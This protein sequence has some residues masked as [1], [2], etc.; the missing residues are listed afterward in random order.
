MPLGT[1][2]TTTVRYGTVVAEAG[3]ELVDLNGHIEL[4]P[5]GWVVVYGDPDLPADEQ[6]HTLVPRSKVVRIE[7]IPQNG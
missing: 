1:A 6:P 2:T 3:L 7:V 4:Q 5:D